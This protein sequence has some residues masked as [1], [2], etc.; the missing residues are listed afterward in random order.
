MA[1]A[2]YVI[3]TRDSK[4]HTG[5]FYV[6]EQVLREEGVTDFAQYAVTAGVEPLPDFFL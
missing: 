6:D 2:A 1:D 5:N 4:Q 3:L